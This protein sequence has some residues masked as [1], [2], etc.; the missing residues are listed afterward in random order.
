[1][2]R[3]VNGATYCNADGEA[4][5]MRGTAATLLVGTPAHTGGHVGA[6]RLPARSCT[7]LSDRERS[8]CSSPAGLRL[9]RKL[10]LL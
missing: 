1:M 6:A 9:K 3:T 10:G 7:A 8:P 4:N 2:W 5:G